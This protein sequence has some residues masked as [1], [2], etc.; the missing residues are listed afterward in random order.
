MNTILQSKVR[1]TQEFSF[2]MAHALDKYEGPCKNIHGHSYKFSITVKG[3]PVNDAGNSC[4]GMVVDFNILKNIVDTHIISKYDHSLLLNDSSDMA[5]RFKKELPGE[6]VIW[7][8]YQ[9]TCENILLEF[10]GILKQQLPG[11][12]IFYNASLR[13]APGSF[14]EW[15]AEDNS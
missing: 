7:T 12:L 13:E 5:K 4:N 1:I 10:V 11:N 9:P 8:S 3:T 6:K 14:V 2:E 15:Y